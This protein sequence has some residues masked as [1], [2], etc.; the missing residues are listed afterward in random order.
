MKKKYFGGLF[1][2]NEIPS[3]YYNVIWFVSQERS[4]I[5]WLTLNLKFKSLFLLH[6]S[7]KEDGD[8][9]EIEKVGEDEVEEKEKLGRENEE[10]QEDEQRIGRIF[11]MIGFPLKPSQDITLPPQQPAIPPILKVPMPP[12]TF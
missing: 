12:L 4:W 5:K 9:L 6:F 2:Y 7:G 3:A 1:Q 11:E 8:Q 10:E